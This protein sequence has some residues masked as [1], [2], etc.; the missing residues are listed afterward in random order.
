MMQNLWITLAAFILLATQSAFFGPA[1][2][3]V[4]PEL[5]EAGDLSRA[6]GALNMLT[7]MAIIFGV[8]VAGPITDLYSPPLDPVTGVRPEP[9]LWAPGVLLIVVA[10]LGLV[11]V[12]FLP[13]LKAGDPNLRYTLNPF[14][15]YIPALKEMATGPLLII[16]LAWAYF[17]LIGMMA[18]LILP[19]YK[20]ILDISYQENGYL[21]GLLGIAIGVGSVL[22]GLI[23][24][25]HIK[26][27]LIPIGAVG[28]TVCF[29]LMGAIKPEFWSL[30]ALLFGTGSFAGFY[31]VPLQALLQKLSPQAERGRFLGTANALSFCLSTL[32]AVIYWLATSILDI[33]PNRVFLLCAALAAT[34]TGFALLR[35]RGYL[36]QHATV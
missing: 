27:G 4:V 21:L 9:V 28:M 8:T 11:A 6:N 3:G 32:G 5:V 10:G 29:G 26:P 12:L 19:E 2:Y 30:G 35:L 1:K 33:P 15:T 36:R 34:G 16:T 14:S 31:I 24:G 20:A 18:L 22:A 25:H 13:R 17:Y 7:N 23:S